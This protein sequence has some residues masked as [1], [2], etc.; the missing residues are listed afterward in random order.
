MAPTEN[1]AL[2]KWHTLQKNTQ[3]LFAK[4][5]AE[6]FLKEILKFVVWFTLEFF[7]LQSDIPI[8]LMGLFVDG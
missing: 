1:G 2:Q 7:L 3:R 8:T 6:W 5:W 4:G